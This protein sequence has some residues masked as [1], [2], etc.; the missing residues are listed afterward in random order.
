MATPSGPTVFSIP[1]SRV[2]QLVLAPMLLSSC[3]GW[4]AATYS[5][6]MRN[7]ELVASARLQG[8]SLGVSFAMLAV[9]LGMTPGVW[10]ASASAR[11]EKR[12]IRPQDLVCISS[13]Q[14]GVAAGAAAL[15][16]GFLLGWQLLPDTGRDTVLRAMRMATAISGSVALAI[17]TLMLIVLITK[18]GRRDESGSAAT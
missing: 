11:A 2:T 17:T 15:A 4:W 18:L 16:E 7:D 8:A 10:A 9:I 3:L 1:R 6:P 5:Y 14:L 12:D 13:R